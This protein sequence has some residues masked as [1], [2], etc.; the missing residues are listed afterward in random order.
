MPAHLRY[1]SVVEASNLQLGFCGA[2][3]LPYGHFNPFELLCIQKQVGS[4]TIVNHANKAI[5]RHKT[6]TH[7]CLSYF[8]LGD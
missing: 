8:Y 3:L 2:E 7:G 4:P 5:Y 6:L 1:Y